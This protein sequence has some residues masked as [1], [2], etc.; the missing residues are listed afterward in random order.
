[1]NV[2]DAARIMTFVVGIGALID[3]FETLAIRGA[4]STTGVYSFAVLRTGRPGV[5]HGAL[6]RPLTWL[7]GYPHVLA[8]SG[9]Q[10]GSAALLVGLAIADPPGYRVAAVLCCGSL[11]LS[12][13]LIHYRNVFGLDGSDQMMVVVLTSAFIALLAGNTVIGVIALGYAAGQLI[14]SY[15]V[16]GYC[17]LISPAWRSGNAI[18][19]ILG[20]VGYGHPVIASNLRKRPLLARMS[21][22][23]VILFECFAPILVFAGVPGVVILFAAG[24]TFHVG[25]AALMGLNVFVWSF[26]A[27]YPALVVVVG[28]IHI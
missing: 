10:I 17:K 3:G 12:R 2:V 19:G 5:N 15:L 9:I 27:A 4:Y 13:L 11:L 8:I 7:F 14:L 18:I 26:A 23:S 1:M 22:W 20:T 6:A 16:A 21:C 25:I 28:H 24:M